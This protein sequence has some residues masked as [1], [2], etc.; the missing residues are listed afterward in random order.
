MTP[1]NH[2]D[3]TALDRLDRVRLLQRDLL[4]EEV[5]RLIGLLHEYRRGWSEDAGVRAERRRDVEDRLPVLD[6]LWRASERAEAWVE[7]P[8][9]DGA[10]RRVLGSAAG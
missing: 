6:W 5:E 4:V 1:W 8:D 10:R 2:A 7:R 3:Q 9:L